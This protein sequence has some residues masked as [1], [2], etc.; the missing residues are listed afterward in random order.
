MSENY[1]YLSKN[2]TPEEPIEIIA[3]G[4]VFV[5]D[6]NGNRYLDLS[7][8]TANLNLGH[9]HPLITSAIEEYIKSERPYF[10]S[11]RW[12]SSLMADLA[13]KLVEISPKGMSKA[14]V[15][16]CN[17]SDALEDA[18]KRSRR[19][20]KKENKQII[21]AQYRSHHGESSETLS[22]SGK[23]FENKS[24]LG[25]S[26]NFIFIE[27]TYTY[28]KPDNLTEEEYSASCSKNL[29]ELV[30]KRGDISAVVLEPIQVTGGVIPQQKSFLK[31]V[32]RICNENNITFILDEVQTAFGWLG[33]MFASDYYEIKPDIIALGKGLSAGFPALAA[34]VFKEEYDNLNYGESEFTN[35][36]EPLACTAALANINYLQ[37]SD[38][39]NTIPK[40][41]T[42]LMERLL[43]MKE[44][45]KQ[46][47]DVRGE[48]L[49][50]G[51]EFIEEDKSE[52][53]KT[54]EK[55]YK[56]ALDKGL[57]LRKASCQ[58][59]G[60]NVL[61]I[62]PPIIINHEQIEESMDI[63]DKSLKEGLR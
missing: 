16:L 35:G 59:K 5:Y 57:I 55:V 27:P 50:L 60:S 42:H 33:T 61:I 20:H 48:C 62:K 54:T 38:I 28:R 46:I 58:G 52:D 21:V 17:G 15:K 31:N 1:R 10:L 39:L 9:R 22:A 53:Y 43:N 6:K 14:N 41:H 19:F 13:A 8:Q 30:K 11:S 2:I 36:G 51:I 12:Q 37:N 49:I 25:G 32:E 47:G 26:K 45:Y 56:S 29:E 40:K 63:L 34:T 18:F 44:R 7:S 23:N 24:E 4:G 3:G